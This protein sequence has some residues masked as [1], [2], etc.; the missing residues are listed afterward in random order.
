MSKQLLMEMADR[1]QVSIPDL[2]RTIAPIKQKLGYNG[3]L[4]AQAVAEI[5]R[6]VQGMKD[7]K[8][9]DEVATQVIADRSTSAK[10]PQ[11]QSQQGK[12]PASSSMERRQSSGKAGKENVMAAAGQTA[13]S[14]ENRLT[15]RAVD[16]ADSATMQYVSTVTNRLANNLQVVDAALNQAFDALDET[17]ECDRISGDSGQTDF[18][19]EGDPTV[20]ALPMAS[21]GL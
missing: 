3:K 17:I 2:E 13:K 10:E 15:K 16:D 7:G 19:L 6:C 14:L 4:D 18:L 11:R 21:L 1:Q 9:L 5:E 8:S 12:A 20:G